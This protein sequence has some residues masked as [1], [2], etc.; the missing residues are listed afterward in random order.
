MSDQ[1]VTFLILN[2]AI[3]DDAMAVEDRIFKVSAKPVSW[4][5]IHGNEIVL[6][7]S[8][9][10][11]MNS[12]DLHIGWLLLGLH[13]GC[14]FRANAIWPYSYGK[15]S[16]PT[17]TLAQCHLDFVLPPTTNNR[18]C[19]RIVFIDDVMAVGVENFFTH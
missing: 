3:I 4:R 14:V 2:K 16:P 12:A 5:F 1:A 10:T 19:A 9:S 11:V 8:Y 13:S 18:S 17:P 15:S 6:K 7:T